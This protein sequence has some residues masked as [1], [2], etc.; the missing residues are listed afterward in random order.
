MPYN[1]LLCSYFCLKREEEKLSDI[2]FSNWAKVP[3]LPLGVADRTKWTLVVFSLFFLFSL[4][5][6]L[7]SQKGVSYGSKIL[8]G[9]H[10]LMFKVDFVDMCAVKYPLVSMGGQSTPVKCMQTGNKKPYRF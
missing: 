1:I 10:N 5:L 4:P 6:L 8:H 9:V 3:A 2:Q 7:V